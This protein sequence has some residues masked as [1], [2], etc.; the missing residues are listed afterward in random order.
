MQKI[1][2]QGQNKLTGSAKINGS[3]NSILSMIAASLLTSDEVILEDVPQLRDIV[4]MTRIVEDL[5]LSTTYDKDT[6]ELKIKFE[7]EENVTACR[8][9][10]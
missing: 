8:A 7:N 2:I 3:K 9:V 1:V 6:R 5:G 10:T 4:T